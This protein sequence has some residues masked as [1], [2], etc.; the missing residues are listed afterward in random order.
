MAQEYCLNS[1]KEIDYDELLETYLLRVEES[2]R[3][4]DGAAYSAI[5]TAVTYNFYDP[6][7]GSYLTDDI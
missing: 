6:H 4:R 7:V 2:E 5:I 1:W 3:N